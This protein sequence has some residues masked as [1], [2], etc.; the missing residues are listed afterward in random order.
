MVIFPKASEKI[1]AVQGSIA[2]KANELSSNQGRPQTTPHI[3]D[4]IPIERPCYGCQIDLTT[5]KA[6]D[7]SDGSNGAK[8]N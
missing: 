3:S 4:C 7:G 5:T 6:A 2:G 1:K 8:S